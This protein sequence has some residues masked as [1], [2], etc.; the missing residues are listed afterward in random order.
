MAFKL[1]VVCLLLVASVGF[2]A[3]KATPWSM[4]SA[5]SACSESNDMV[6]CAKDQFMSFIDSLFQRDSFKVRSKHLQVNIKDAR[7]TTL[8]APFLS[9]SSTTSK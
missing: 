2:S 5:A 7:T 3:A 6:G 1:Q 9:R 8:F 4:R